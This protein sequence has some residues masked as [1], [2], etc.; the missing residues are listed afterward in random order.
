MKVVDVR[1]TLI[2]IPHLGGYQDATVRHPE[3]GHSVLFAHVLTDTGLE[4]LG[5]GCG[6]YPVREIIERNLKP[7]LVAP[8]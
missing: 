8:V 3:K 7:L 2:S 1:T 6:G 5:P 4:G